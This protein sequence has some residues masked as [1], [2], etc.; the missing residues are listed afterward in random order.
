MTTPSSE[1]SRRQ[2]LHLQTSL[3]IGGPAYICPLCTAEF[4][5]EP[6][7]WQHA[8]ANH[9]SHFTSMG[10][11]EEAEEKERFVKEAAQR[12]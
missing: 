4:P 5:A 2:F 3:G 11:P 8:I 6:R 10:T 9:P 1:F 7:L 12:A